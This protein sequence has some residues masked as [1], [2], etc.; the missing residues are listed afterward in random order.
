MA[1]PLRRSV[2]EQD[3]NILEEDINHRVLQ[4]IR[5]REAEKKEGVNPLRR[6]V[7]QNEREESIDEVPAFDKNV[8]KHLA[9]K[10][11]HQGARIDETPLGVRATMSDEEAESE[12]WLGMV[13]RGVNQSFNRIRNATKE[14]I[15]NI[16]KTSISPEVPVQGRELEEDE[17]DVKKDEYVTSTRL[18]FEDV[19]KDM[20]VGMPMSEYE[21]KKKQAQV[22]YLNRKLADEG[23]EV[24]D[25]I[26]QVDNRMYEL[27]DELSKKIDKVEQINKEIEASPVRQVT[28]E[29]MELIEEIRDLENE[30]ERFEDRREELNNIISRNHKRQISNPLVN[31]PASFV[32]G[33]ASSMESIFNFYKGMVDKYTPSDTVEGIINNVARYTGKD[34]LYT[35]LLD[36]DQYETPTERSLASRYYVADM[37][38]NFINDWK[39]FLA[40]DGEDRKLIA[41]TMPKD[42]SRDRLT[43]PR[44]WATE[45]PE[46]LGS[47]SPYLALAFA[48]GKAGAGKALGLSL[49]TKLGIKSPKVASLM[50]MVSEG[51]IQAGVSTPILTFSYG[52]SAME[53]S[54]L[55]MG[56]DEDMVTERYK[57]IPEKDRKKIAEA[58]KETAK[59]IAP[60]TLGLNFL[61]L[62]LAYGHG[63]GIGAVT[64]FGSKK[65][66]AGRMALNLGRHPVV[67]G[68]QIGEELIQESAVANFGR[69]AA[70]KDGITVGEFMN[71]DEGKR[72]MFGAAMIGT[73]HTALGAFSSK[74]SIADKQHRVIK[75]LDREYRRNKTLFHYARSGDDVELE[76]GL[77]DKVNKGEVDPVTADEIRS[78]VKRLRNDPDF[79]ESAHGEMGR[80]YTKLSDRLMDIEREMEDAT[81]ARREALQEEKAN[82]DNELAKFLNLHREAGADMR[83]DRT[84][85]GLKA[86]HKG[87]K[88]TRDQM[89]ERQ[90]NYYDHID[91]RVQEEIRGETAEVQPIYKLEGE[92]VELRDIIESIEEVQTLEEAQEFLDNPDKY[93]VHNDFKGAARIAELLNSKLKSLGHEGVQTFGRSVK[94]PKIKTETSLTVKTD[95]QAAAGK[96][97]ALNI[98]PEELSVQELKV[99]DETIGDITIQ[100]KKKD[101]VVKE[102]DMS[103]DNRN[104]GY[105]REFYNSLNKKAKE[106]GARVV[107]DNYE[108]LTPEQVDTWE[109][110]ERTGHAEKLADRYVMTDLVEPGKVAP[111][112]LVEKKKE[113]KPKE[114][115]LEEVKPVEEKKPQYGEGLMTE[116]K[117]KTMREK[118]AEVDKSIEDD[119]RQIKKVRDKVHKDQKDKV[120]RRA[121]EDMG[122]PDK[123]KEFIESRKEG[124]RDM[125]RGVTKRLLQRLAN[126]EYGNPGEVRAFMRYLDKVIDSA[127][128][129]AELRSRDYY[130]EKILR[131]I[132]PKKFSKIDAQTKRAVGKRVPVEWAD[133]VANIRERML[134]G[135]Y[136]DAQQQIEQLYKDME[137]ESVENPS[138]EY[139]LDQ[140][141]LSRLEELSYEGVLNTDKASSAQLK[142]AYNA[143]MD[144]INEGRTRF[145]A[146]R[147]LKQEY[148]EG[149]KKSAIDVITGKG[150]KAILNHEQLAFQDELISPAKRVYDKI[151]RQFDWASHDS[152]LSLL[153]KMSRFDKESEIFDSFLN[154]H[155]GGQRFLAQDAYQ[156]G[157]IDMY[158]RIMQKANEIFGEKHEKILR[159]SSVKKHKI[160]YKDQFGVEREIISTANTAAKRYGELQNPELYPSLQKDGWV[161]VD[162]NPTDKYNQV[163]KL[164]TPEHKEWIDWKI[165]ELYPELYDRYNETYR[166][167]YGTDMPRE[168]IYTPVYTPDAAT[169]KGD[170][171][172]DATPTA[173]ST[174]VNHHTIKRIGHKKGLAFIDDDNVMM[175]YVDKMEFF[176]SH[177]DFIKDLNTVFKDKDVRNAIES[178][179]PGRKYL[180]YMDW[181]IDQLAGKPHKK[182]VIELALDSFRKNFTIASLSLKPQIG[183]KQLM[184]LPAYWDA[185]P[186]YAAGWAKYSARFFAPEGNVK[187]GAENI[188]KLLDTPY[189]K[190]RYKRGW[191]RDVM[192][193]LARDANSVV[194]S[195]RIKFKDA[196]MITTKFGDRAAII[197]GGAAVYQHAYEQ[198]LNQDY[199]TEQAEHAAKKAFVEITQNTQQS[200]LGGDLSYIQAASTYHKLLTMFSTAPL[201]YHRKAMAAARGLLNKRGHAWSNAKTFFTYHV[202][203]PQ[204]FQLATNAFK[205]GTGGE[206]DPWHIGDQYRAAILG[207]F[208][209]LFLVGTAMETIVDVIYD[210]PWARQA[211]QMIPAVDLI[212]KV[213]DATFELESL[214]EEEFDDLTIDEVIDA[215]TILSEIAGDLTG[216][217]V[218]AIVN[219]Y[220]AIADIREDETNF[221]FRRAFGWS[222]WAVDREGV[223]LLNVPEHIERLKKLMDEQEEKHE[224]MEEILVP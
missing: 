124:L 50:N 98:R 4:H 84:K 158:N 71:T 97:E 52:G 182:Y 48:L 107:S 205:W 172:F 70:G 204:L 73:G 3:F 207:N 138:S 214:F 9:R 194:K 78:K 153:D 37:A 127:N 126:I 57:E 110:L 1:N 13:Q 22:I 43:D 12:G 19:I 51:M 157:I 121:A 39:N 88:I 220:E 53:R 209:H 92:N 147:M 144:I 176:R 30:F 191:D 77:Q 81:G 103:V 56:Y 60:R 34:L 15:E 55:E 128:L 195:K 125:G 10:L 117:K 159:R 40:G 198:A 6:A 82:I 156:Q 42:F 199:T 187:K 44:F 45:A 163:E 160:K 108:N 87:K 217:P 151:V 24:M 66:K 196:M 18:E 38:A 215:V 25:E 93:V 212:D 174:A 67:M 80:I 185:I 111:T 33:M 26:R 69:L 175:R 167:I 139:N 135:D 202:L 104:R 168:A 154:R 59:Y 99:D 47:S 65:A 193:A 132:D 203:L 63:A 112:R 35:R 100:Q 192:E 200:A 106:Q 166:R 49:T 148:K 143:L 76:A 219:T 5:Q 136:N 141:T 183:V 64:R 161:D 211:T 133:K 170:V 155:F 62:G 21:R 218:Q 181:H 27:Q 118:K 46:M 41:S 123:I 171:L 140:E 152:F 29:D 68:G 109:S 177:A 94:P 83:I 8:P 201:Q 150:R 86:I 224:D 178:A 186:G 210:K 142:A 119:L 2:K 223:D 114:V 85:K 179:F 221:P 169:K 149:L 101:W 146:Q 95:E 130:T 23:E 145:N 7:Q 180:E 102:D 91:N 28:E 115:K 173:M 206:D 89:T 79:Q 11:S 14:A 131:E 165:N 36:E 213:G 222:E 17:E 188:R 134:T 58:G 122:L 90:R 137:K 116:A 184:S 120:A 164:L 190:H 61:Q 20:R 75:Q 129:R 113:A 32:S 208:N 72:T 197:L 189:M 74:T 16:A 31:I 96:A 54:A 162:G 216:T 105:D